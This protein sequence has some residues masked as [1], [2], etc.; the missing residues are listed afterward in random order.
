MEAF[1][2]YGPNPNCDSDVFFKI[3]NMNC[4]PEHIARLGHTSLMIALET[5]GVNPNCNHGIFLKLLESRS[6][7]PASFCEYDKENLIQSIK[8]YESNPKCDSRVFLKLILLLEPLI[9]KPE[10]IVL[11]DTYTE[12]KILKNKILDKYSKC[13]ELINKCLFI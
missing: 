12:N 6:C 3:L 4:L 2:H 11:L 5:Y 9:T 10:L 1:I 13:R 7:L 8:S